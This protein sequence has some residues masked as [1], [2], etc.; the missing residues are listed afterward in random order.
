MRIDSQ[1]SSATATTAVGQAAAVLGPQEGEDACDRGVI[2]HG[3]QTVDLEINRGKGTH[4][5]VSDS[6][7]CPAVKNAFH[8]TGALSQSAPI[9][10]HI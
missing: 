4:R 3:C 6:S 10:I 1:V 9:R 7:H 2:W 5:V 8:N